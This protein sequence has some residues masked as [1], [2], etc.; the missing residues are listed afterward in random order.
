MQKDS[1]KLVEEISM[2]IFKRILK[3]KSEGPLKEYDEETLEETLRRIV[4]S[5]KFFIKTLSQQELKKNVE[6]VSIPVFER[7]AK[8]FRK[9]NCRTI[10]QGNSRRN[11][12]DICLRNLIR[13]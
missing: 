5:E 8:R 7:I 2:K 10:F 6:E 13:N 4:F 11:L 3:K 1:S 9:K 12:I